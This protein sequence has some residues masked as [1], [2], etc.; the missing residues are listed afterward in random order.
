MIDGGATRDPKNAH[1]SNFEGDPGG[2][3]ES[4]IDGC[5]K[6]PKEGAL[7]KLDLLEGDPDGEVEVH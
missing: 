2:E 7:L 3:I 1:S 6:G 5:N 4:P